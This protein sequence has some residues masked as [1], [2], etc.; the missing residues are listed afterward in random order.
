MAGIPIDNAESYVETLLDAGYRVAIADQVEDPDEVS[1]VVERAV[2]RIVTPGTLTESELLGGADNN[3][4]AALTAGERYGLA[5]L[6]I[7][8][9]DCYATS[10]GSESAVA[11][12]LSRSAP[13]K[14]SSGRTSTWTGTP[15]SGRP[16]W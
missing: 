12:E 8:T 11:D 6:D 14:P 16:V 2:T 5:L 3:Y 10:V 15:S 1:G 13:P 4:V 7:S 9:G